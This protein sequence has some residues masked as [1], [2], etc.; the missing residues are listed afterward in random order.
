[1]EGKASGGR[2][3]ASSKK[4]LCQSMRGRSETLAHPVHVFS[5]HVYKGMTYSRFDPLLI[6]PPTW[7]ST[8]AGVVFSFATSAQT[9]TL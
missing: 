6:S 4:I 1:M 3:D 2:G 9:Q 8:A 7:T 5:V